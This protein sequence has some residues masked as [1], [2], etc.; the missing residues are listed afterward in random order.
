VAVLL[1]VGVMVFVS[2]IPLVAKQDTIIPAGENSPMKCSPQTVLFLL[3]QN[4]STGEGKVSTASLAAIQSTVQKYL[5]TSSSDAI[6]A[7]SV[8]VH[9][10]SVSTKNSS[11]RL[12]RDVLDNR[13]E[14]V[15]ENSVPEGQKLLSVVCSIVLHKKICTKTFLKSVQDLLATIELELKDIIIEN[16]VTQTTTTTT[17]TQA[18]AKCEDTP[19]YIETVTGHTCQTYADYGLCEE[20]KV[21]PDAPIDEAEAKANCCICGKQ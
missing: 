13:A 15:N 6:A 21:L 14:V 19:G 9:D 17:T 10:A 20:F 11:K 3:P 1:I 8:Q 16:T 4:S 18:P 5:R 2:L 7:G 12:T